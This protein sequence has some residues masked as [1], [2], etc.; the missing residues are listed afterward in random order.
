MRLPL[1]PVVL[2]R[3]CLL[4]ATIARAGCSMTFRSARVF[5]AECFI[6]CY[7]LGSKYIKLRQAERMFSHTWLQA[8]GRDQPVLVAD[9]M[10]Y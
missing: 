8:D 1:S 7:A 5:T 4:S 2:Q 6:I 3:K 10:W 9:M